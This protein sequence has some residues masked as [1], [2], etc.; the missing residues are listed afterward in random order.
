V[1]CE[2]KGVSITIYLA[3]G[4][5]I[6][7]IAIGL[8]IG[9]IRSIPPSN[10]I[11]WPFFQRFF[12]TILYNLATFY[13]EIMRGL[14]T[15]VFLLVTGYI[16]IPVFIKT[17]NTEIVPIIRIV[18][19]A[20]EFPAIIWRGRDF[21]T[22]ILGLSLIYGAFMSEIFR[23]GIQSIDKGQ[24]EASRSLGMSYFQLMRYIVIPQSVRNVLPPLGNEFI[25]I[26]KDT[27]LVTILGIAEM[28][29]YARRWSGSTFKYLET[30]LILCLIYL[31]MTITGSLLV[32][33]MDHYLNE[34][35]RDILGG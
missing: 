33:S 14:P 18:F 13:V 35:K 19:N 15:I 34:Y 2:I 25:S 5:Y 28:T 21:S 8:L 24:T 1:K 26:I 31:A 30:Y 22:A 32:R 27:S 3:I 9:V 12:Y 11:Q 20:P 17:I 6:I 10:F 16:I 7:A 4:S 23:A 29:Q